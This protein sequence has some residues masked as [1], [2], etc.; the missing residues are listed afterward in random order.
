MLKTYLSKWKCAVDLSYLS[1]WKCA[2]NFNVSNFKQ[3]VFQ[4]LIL[5]GPQRSDTTST[6]RSALVLPG[7]EC[8]DLRTESK[9]LSSNNLKEFSCVILLRKFCVHF[10]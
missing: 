5:S 8:F 3:R 2:I 9:R 1:K 6:P 7:G 4:V 10:V